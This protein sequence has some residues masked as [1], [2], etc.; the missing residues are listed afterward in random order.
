MAERITLDLSQFDGVAYEP[1]QLIVEGNGDP[2]NNDRF[3]VIHSQHG[4]HRATTYSA[5]TGDLIAAAPT[6]LAYARQEHERAERLAASHARLLR[7]VEQVTRFTP[8]AEERAVMLEE[9]IA[10]ARALTGDTP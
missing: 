4:T 9:V 1:W 5:T 8:W 6:L 3:V 7:H 10:S 2:S